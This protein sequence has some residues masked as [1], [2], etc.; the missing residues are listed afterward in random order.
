MGEEE[1]AIGGPGAEFE[2]KKRRIGLLMGPVLA[3]AAALIFDDSVA[4][5][6]IGLMVLCVT[7]W[8]TEALP[9][10]AVALAAAMGAVLTGLAT[11]E[12]AFKAF[13]TPLLFMFVGSFFIAEAMQVHG[14]G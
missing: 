5:A 12:I 4:P 6:L 13:G 7:W 8:L 11:P 10:A 9:V 14:L 1:E 3:L 2:A